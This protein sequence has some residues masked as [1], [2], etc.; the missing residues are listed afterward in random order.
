MEKQDKIEIFNKVAS[1]KI[2]NFD[3]QQFTT[4]QKKF[5][6]TILC[7]FNLNGCLV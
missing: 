5:S 4:I 2:K 6:I 7:Y 3:L 1:R